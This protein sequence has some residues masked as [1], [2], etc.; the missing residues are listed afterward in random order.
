M[1]RN[2][3]RLVLDEEAR[4]SR[5]EGGEGCA[6]LRQAPRRFRRSRRRC[7]PAQFEA[8]RPRR[9]EVR[10]GKVPV[11]VIKR[12]AG[13]NGEAACEHSCQPVEQRQQL[14]RHRNRI[15]RL[16]EGDECSVEIEEQGRVRKVGERR[17]RING[18]HGRPMPKSGRARNESPLFMNNRSTCYVNCGKNILPATDCYRFDLGY[19]LRPKGDIQWPNRFWRKSA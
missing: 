16:R 7:P 11:E 17:R 13:K 12:T 14:G 9:N 19:S 8:M 5:R 4:L 6:R 2:A 3:R 15:G 1:E 10:C 18:I